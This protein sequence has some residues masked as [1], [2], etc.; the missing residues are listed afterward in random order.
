MEGHV[1]AHSVKHSD[2]DCPDLYMD[3]NR[4]DL[5]GNDRELLS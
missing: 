5:G 4:A 1:I 2:F 3:L